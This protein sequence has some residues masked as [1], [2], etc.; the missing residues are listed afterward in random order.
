MK[1]FDTSYLARLY[2]EDRGWE[3][4]RE[5]AATDHLACSVHGKAEC[6]AAFHRKFREGVISRKDL[7]ELLNQFVLDCEAGAFQWLPLSDPVISRL[8]AV[9]TTLPGTE[10]LC[11]ADAIH[12]SSAAENSF[13]EIY[14]NDA[15]LLKASAHFGLKGVNVI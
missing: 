10:L 9:Y 3:P 8:M 13:P 5:L 12:L 2:L 14:S 1:Y 6:I 15:R 4:V 11:A 7:G